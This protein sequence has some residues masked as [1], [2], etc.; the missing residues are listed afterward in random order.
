[1][2]G[3]SVVAIWQP[4]CIQLWMTVIHIKIKIKKNKLTLRECSYCSIIGC[5]SAKERWYTITTCIRLRL[6]LKIEITNDADGYKCR[7]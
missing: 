6:Q 3:M 2:F 4:F 7:L 1:M 5:R